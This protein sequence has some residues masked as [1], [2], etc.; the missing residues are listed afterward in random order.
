MAK[1]THLEAKTTLRLPHTIWQRSIC[2]W[3][4]FWQG[5]DIG[6]KAFAAFAGGEILALRT[7]KEFIKDNASIEPDQA[8]ADEDQATK[9]L[10][11]LMTKSFDLERR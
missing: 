3:P 11:R 5:Q 4:R 7:P 9:F 6:E 8:L 2:C 10:C 1:R